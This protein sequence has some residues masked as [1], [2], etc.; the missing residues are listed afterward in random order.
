MEDTVLVDA[1]WVAAHLDDPDVRVV[2]V[3]VS[4]AAYDEGHIPGAILWDAY[5]DLRHPDFSP[6]DKAEFEAVL[7]RTALTPDTT[8][9]FY[10]YAPVLGYWLLSRHGHERTKVLDGPRER[11]AEEGR[12]WSTEVPEPGATSYVSDGGRV[13]LLA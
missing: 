6:I 2:E 9:V 12:E 5:K 11:W 10:G 8:V 3:D 7:A 13:G 4:S 1:D